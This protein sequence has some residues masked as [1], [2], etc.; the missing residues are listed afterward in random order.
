MLAS[1]LSKREKFLPPSATKQK[2]GHAVIKMSASALRSA[3]NRVSLV[4]KKL[5]QM[6]YLQ[7]MAGAVSRTMAQTIMHPANT[8]KTMLQLKEIQTCQSRSS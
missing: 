8:F 1:R 5:A 6:T 7:Y 3:S 2:R 4:S